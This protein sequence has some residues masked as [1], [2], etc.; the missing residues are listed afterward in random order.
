ML[1]S[2]S[3]LMERTIQV[4][5]RKYKQLI[6]YVPRSL[7]TDSAFPFKPHDVLRISILRDALSIEK[8]KHH[9]ASHPAPKTLPIAD[10][11]D[12]DKAQK[13][14]IEKN[15]QASNFFWK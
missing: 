7:A 6:I 12:G 13:K 8:V 14:D 15:T 4:K 9:P 11:V 5:G 2:D 10:N 1:E 3:K